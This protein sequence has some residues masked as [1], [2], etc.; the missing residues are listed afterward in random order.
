MKNH[1]FYRGVL[2]AV[3]L[4]LCA[5]VCFGQ[6]AQITGRVTDSTDAVIPDVSIMV[7]NVD[8]GI[9]RDTASNELGYYTVSLL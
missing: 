6:T 2:P 1:G 3:L 4:P 9:K 5:L 8:T 7:T